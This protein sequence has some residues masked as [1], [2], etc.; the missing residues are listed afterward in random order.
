MD[1]LEALFILLFMPEALVGCLIGLVAAGAVHWLAT[2]PEPVVLE[3]A[4]V[5][6][7]F[8]LGLVIGGLSAKGKDGSRE[9]R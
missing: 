3:A 7:G 9:R 5:A 1:F 6:G 2:E 8:M 4:L